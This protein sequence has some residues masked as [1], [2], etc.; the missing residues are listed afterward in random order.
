MDFYRVL[1][2]FKGFRTNR[3]LIVMESDDWGAIRMPDIAVYN[4]LL[5]LGVRVDKDPYTRYDSIAGSTD[6]DNLFEILLKFKDSVGRNPVITANT[7]MANPDFKKIR[8]SD[9]STYYF[10][11]FTETLKMRFNNESVFEKWK[12]GI[13]ARI[14]FPQFHGREHLYVKNWM[15]D[16]RA[17]HRLT[18][19]AFDFG[20]CSLTTHNHPDIKYSYMGALNSGLPQDIF[21]FKA[22]NE[23]GLRMFYEIFGYK[24]ASYIPTTYTWHPDIEAP[25]YDLGVRFIQGLPHQRVPLDDNK[26]FG[27]KKDNFL[28]TQSKS[29]LIYFNRNAFFEPS[30][31]SNRDWVGSCL[32]RIKLAFLMRRPAVISM[33]RLNFIGSIVP[34]NRD[35]NLKSFEVLIKSIIKYFPKVEFLNST[36]LGGIML[37]DFTKS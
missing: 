17:G 22:I 33:H 9:F 36:E 18:R 14:W 2:L 31:V 27:F 6:L 34:E 24:S 20:C 12:S 21:N 30:L 3:Q 25:L 16:L 7:I 11:P 19:L 5:K 8:E 28:G 4:A 32:K 1:G 13:E 23:E 37:G 26:K 10:E 29:G 35:K 15:N